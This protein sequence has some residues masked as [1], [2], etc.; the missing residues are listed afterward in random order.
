[1]GSKIAAGMEAAYRIT[2][3]PE[4]IDS[5][6]QQLVVVTEREKFLVP[7][8]AVG[9]AAA[10]DLPDSITLPAVAAKKSSRRSLLVTNVGRKAGSFQLG[11][12]S[13]CFS[14]S[15]AR[16]TLAPGE[17]LQLTLDFT[18]PAPGQ[19][20]GE[21]EVVYE[22]SSRTTFT[23]L[24]GQGL[25]LEVGLSDSQVVFLP[26]C[27]GK[28]SQRTVKLINRSS[29]TVAF[30]IRC[31][32]SPD[33]EI[34]AACTALAAVQQQGTSLSGTGIAAVRGLS[35]GGAGS[36][37]RYGRSRA[38]SSNG[39]SCQQQQLQEQQ[40]AAAGIDIDMQDES[41]FL[42]AAGLQQQQ[43]QQRCSTASS[44]GASEA[45]WLVGDAQLAALRKSK[46][47]RLDIAAD[48]QLFGTQ[49]FAAFPP[50]GYVYPNSEQ[51]V[52]LQFAPDCA[53][54]FEAVAWVELQGLGER[55][56]LQLL[57]QGVGAQVVFSYENVDIGE[58][59]VNTEHCYEVELLSRGKVD[60][61]WTLQPC[62][63]RFGSKFSFSPS[64]GLLQPGAAQVIAVR[65][66][67]DI[68]GQFEESFQL[69]LAGSSRPVPLAFRG[70]VVG[71]QFTLDTQALDYG[72]MSYGF[73]WAELAGHPACKTG[74]LQGSQLAGRPACRI[75]SG[76][77]LLYHAC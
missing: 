35:G 67:S 72:I 16:A 24:Q 58:A 14:V 49:H 17:T 76:L 32:P 12:S 61:E 44:E 40:Q 74:S 5:C 29:S 56:P 42:Q 26:T 25:Q 7:L 45:D 31:Q 65:L 47:A 15:P 60:A 3:A 75:S 73:R 1:V 59:F 18:P 53:E 46:R 30:S 77:Q 50:E 70:A 37:S 20:Q 13:S 41:S 33:A 62:H 55:L 63:T 68:L 22:D 6:E 51:E 34:A 21:L 27:M 19:H 11:C 54:Q 52:V 71:P 38:G 64:S 4:S 39:S 28:L 66:L 2:F 9:A 57:G 69:F 8:L 10:L 36:R 23:A 48:K 43:Q